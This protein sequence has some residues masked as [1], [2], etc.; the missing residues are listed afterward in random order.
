MSMPK[1]LLDISGYSRV[2]AKLLYDSADD[3]RPA[4]VRSSEASS[5]HILYQGEEYCLDMQLE[6]SPESNGKVRGMV[7]VGQ[8]ADLQKPLEPLSDIPFILVSGD[9]LLSEGKSNGFGEFHLEFEPKETVQLLA[10]IEEK[11]LLEVP[12]G[13]HLKGWAVAASP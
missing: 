9:E 7:V 13:R 10:N 8:I 5:R 6:Q 1:R 2:P 11:R 4:G 12:L 3:L